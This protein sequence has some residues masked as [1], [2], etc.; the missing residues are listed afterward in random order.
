MELRPRKT[1]IKKSNKIPPIKALKYAFSYLFNES[2]ANEY[3]KINTGTGPL[4]KGGK[5]AD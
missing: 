2:K 4:K 1:G 3:M 5:N